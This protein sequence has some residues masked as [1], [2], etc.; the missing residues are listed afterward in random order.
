[1]LGAGAR[2]DLSGHLLG[3]VS[4]IG[5][6]YPGSRFRHPL[7][8]SKQGIFAGL[9]IVIIAGAWVIAFYYR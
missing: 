6:G 3:A 8:R 1:M 7:P 9:S 5:L 4:G 2:A